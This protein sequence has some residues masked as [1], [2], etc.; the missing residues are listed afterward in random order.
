MVKV[1]C[2]WPVGGEQRWGVINCYVDN[3][4]MFFETICWACSVI[5]GLEARQAERLKMMGIIS[6]TVNSTKTKLNWTVE[7]SKRLF[8]TLRAKAGAEFN[9]G[10]RE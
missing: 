2:D 8:N 5:S 7:E 3:A 6:G 10:G 1:V 4:G 9:R